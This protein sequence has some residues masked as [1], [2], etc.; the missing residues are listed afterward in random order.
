MCQIV[1]ISFIIFNFYLF[2]S[3]IIFSGCDTD[4]EPWKVPQDGEN[5]E[6][7]DVFTG[8]EIVL[9]LPQD[10]I[11]EEQNQSDFFPPDITA[12]DLSDALVDMDVNNDEG[13]SGDCQWVMVVDLGGETL[14]VR[15][16][17]HLTAS[18][19]GQL[20]EGAIVRVIGTAH[21]D[22]VTD[23]SLG[24]SSDLW[25]NIEFAGGDGWIT[26]V[27]AVCHE[28]P[29]SGEALNWVWPVTGVESLSPW[30]ITCEFGCS[31][32]TYLG[33]LA[34]DYS[35]GD[36]I[37]K[38]IFAVADGVVAHVYRNIGNYKDIIIIRHQLPTPTSAGDSVL[39]SRYGHTGAEVNQGES[40]VAGQRIGT[41]VETGV[42]APH[43]HFEIVNETAQYQ[44]PFCRGCEAAGIFMGPG[45]AGYDFDGSGI[46]WFD[47]DNDGIAGNRFY[48]PSRVIETDGRI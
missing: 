23:T 40:V 29:P 43:L 34:E 42:F 37:G 16:S 48:K 11:S 9:E 45:Y 27:Y 41:I 17:P 19:I 4:K 35:M 33:H 6:Q 24:R 14:N 2:V 1:R 25:Y 22:M 39:Y 20:S 38:P 31:W 28:E 3:T 47:P 46:D 7:Q 10:I 13:S 15:D 5:I 32:S 18:V 36:D 12:D 8:N 44:G 21:G 26:S 30:R